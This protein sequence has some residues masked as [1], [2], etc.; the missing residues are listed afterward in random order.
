MAQRHRTKPTAGML[1]DP[2]PIET[3]KDGRLT[4]QSVAA[5]S[6]FMAIVTA[7][8]NGELTL[9]DGTQ[10][11]WTGN[12]NGQFIRTVSPGTA[13]TEWK[14]PHGLGR[15]PIGWIPLGQNKAGVLYYDSASW[16]QREIKLKSS[17]TTVTYIGI[18]V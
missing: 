14:E 18:L 1:A 15:Q 2:V 4:E 11:G 9:G 3:D 17:G 13:D 12:L 7:L 16:G 8:L 6:S 5:I 10:S